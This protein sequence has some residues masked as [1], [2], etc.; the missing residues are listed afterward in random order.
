MQSFEVVEVVVGLIH[1]V[2]LGVVGVERRLQQLGVGLVHQEPSDMERILK[3][4][5]KLQENS[6]ADRD[7]IYL[8]AWNDG[9][10][11]VYNFP[12]ATEAAPE[13]ACKWFGTTLAAA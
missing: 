9:G 2:G 11:V 7:C 1:S 12:P 6:R 13:A 4:K 10:Y 8:K 5:A 3:D